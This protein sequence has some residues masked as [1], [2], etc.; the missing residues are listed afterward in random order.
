MAVCIL[1]MQRLD[2]ITSKKI[3][4]HPLSK[5]FDGLATELTSN[6][7]EY[8]EHFKQKRMVITDQPARQWCLPRIF[9]LPKCM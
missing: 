6:K 3:I 8:T 7:H 1:V 5:K 2:V 9:S 4:K